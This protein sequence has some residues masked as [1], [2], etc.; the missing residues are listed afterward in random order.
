VNFI[1][2]A[3]R[4]FLGGGGPAR[5]RDVVEK[6]AV[7]GR[8]NE[9]AEGKVAETEGRERHFQ[10]FRLEDAIVNCRLLHSQWLREA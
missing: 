3:L 10:Q 2:F 5:F 6:D 8:I 7:A 4:S 9:L 1:P